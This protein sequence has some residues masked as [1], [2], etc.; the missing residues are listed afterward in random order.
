MRQD[1]LASMDRL[2]EASMGLSSSLD[3]ACYR[4][5]FQ[6]D[7][8]LEAVAGSKSQ[9]VAEVV[10]SLPAPAVLW[11]LARRFVEGLVQKLTRSIPAENCPCWYLDQAIAPSQLHFAHRQVAVR[12]VDRHFLG[13]PV[14]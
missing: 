13:G 11:V 8:L 6:P 12:V 3:L 10:A 4:C 5:L 1:H 7:A 14:R 2:A 9:E